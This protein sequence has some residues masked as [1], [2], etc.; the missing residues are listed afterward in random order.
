VCR[1][2]DG[3]LLAS[4]EDPSWQWD[5]SARLDAVS[6]SLVAP[7]DGLDELAVPESAAPQVIGCPSGRQPSR[8]DKPAKERPALRV[9]VVVG[10][11][12]AGKKTEAICQ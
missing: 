11:G 10:T 12:R 4:S 7:G 5:L 8:V 1:R 3:W 2:R 6:V 9:R